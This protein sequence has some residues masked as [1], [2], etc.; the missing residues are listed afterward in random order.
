MEGIDVAIV[1]LLERIADRIEDRFGRL[2]A[3]LATLFLTLGSLAA[4]VA[5]GWYILR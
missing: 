5:I 4:I 3:I 1:A 2:V